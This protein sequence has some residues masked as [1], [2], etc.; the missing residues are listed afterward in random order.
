MEE[1]ATPQFHV[2]AINGT[3][4]RYDYIGAALNTNELMRLI[5]TTGPAGILSILAETQPPE[6][7]IKRMTP[8][9]GEALLCPATDALLRQA[10]KFHSMRNGDIRLV[11]LARHESGP[12]RVFSWFRDHCDSK[13][14]IEQGEGH[15]TS[16][17]A[18]STAEEAFL[19]NVLTSHHYYPLVSSAGITNWERF[20]S[21]YH[22]LAPEIA[23]GIAHIVKTSVNRW[24]YDVVEQSSSQSVLAQTCIRL[25]EAA[26]PWIATRIP[27]D[28]V[29]TLNAMYSGGIYSL[30]D[31]SRCTPNQV[32][33][34]PNFGKRS[35]ASLVNALLNIDSRGDFASQP[36]AV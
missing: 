36:V 21:D 3:S 28:N 5:M 12:D 20:Y 18:C 29:R 35:L 32:N 9:P 31:L 1:R 13:S 8:Q 25:S 30:V 6:T 2:Y 11:E 10:G 4:A 16:I 34:L 15:P 26:A 22:Y 14:A 33:K 19:H 23:M 17:S 24:V 7:L 27:V